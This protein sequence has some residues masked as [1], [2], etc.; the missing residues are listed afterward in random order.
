DAIERAWALLK[1]KEA[2]AKVAELRGMYESMRN[3]MEELE[4][5]DRRLFEAAKTGSDQNE[6]VTFPKRL[7]VPTETPP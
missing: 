2:V 7:R 4:R 1:Q 3:A 6:V 5:T